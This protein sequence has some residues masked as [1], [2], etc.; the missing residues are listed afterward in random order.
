MLK[1]NL[2]E[3]LLLGP[4]GAEVYHKLSTNKHAITRNKYLVDQQ[5]TVTRLMPNTPVM[6]ILYNIS[7]ICDP[8]RITVPKWRDEIVRLLSLGWSLDG[9]NPHSAQVLQ[10]CSIGGANG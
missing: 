4:L 3:L 8:V 1:E 7:N 6:M 2:I 5:Q 10:S 9:H